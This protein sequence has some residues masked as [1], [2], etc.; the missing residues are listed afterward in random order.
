M[1]NSDNK[2]ILRHRQGDEHLFEP[3]LI[4][5]AQIEIADRP[6][7]VKLPSPLIKLDPNSDFAGLRL[8]ALMTYPSSDLS[9]KYMLATMGS[10][11][12]ASAE[13]MQEFSNLQFDDQIETMAERLGVKPD[14]VL[15]YPWDARS[16]CRNQPG[17][18][19]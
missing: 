9:Q 1:K 6:T 14:D 5:M 19:C 7:E 13:S 15:V 18:H 11:M 3:Q 12:L 2:D 4:P 8:I 10:L 17:R 16:V